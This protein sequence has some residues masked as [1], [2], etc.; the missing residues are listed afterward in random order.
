MNC[1]A[2]L[3]IYCKTRN[4]PGYCLR[5]CYFEG[6]HTIEVCDFRSSQSKLCVSHKLCSIIVSF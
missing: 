2:Y 6:F 3:A 4:V 5:I 1:V